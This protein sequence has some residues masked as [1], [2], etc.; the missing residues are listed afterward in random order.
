MA[1]PASNSDLAGINFTQVYTPPATGAYNFGTSNPDFVIG[2]IANGAKGSM[3]VY[4]LV[5]AGAITGL[6]YVV[7][8]NSAFT[9]VMMSNSVGAFGDK[10]GVAPAAALVGDYIW[11]QVY[12]AVDQMRASVAGTANAPLASSVTAG[13]VSTTVTTPTKNLPGMVF[14][15]VQGATGLFAAQLN[16]PTVGTTN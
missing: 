5:G 14:T 13:A 10:V 11:I 12:G 4:C 7:T 9:C 8:I 15:V 2:T 16:W 1:I 6:G 3:W